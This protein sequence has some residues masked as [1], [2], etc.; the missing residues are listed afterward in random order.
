M[1]SSFLIPLA[2]ALGLSVSI[3]T[4]VPDADA[5][6]RAN[7]PDVISI[8]DIKKGMKGYGL[9]VFEGTKPQ[10]FDVEVIDVLHNFQPR[11][12]LI[13][14]KTMHPRLDVAKIVAGMSGSPI[15]FNGKMAG[16]YAYGWT[17]GVEPVAGVTPIR[18]MLD[19][20]ERP[21]PKLLHGYPLRTLPGKKSARAS[22]KVGGRYA[23]ELSDY[24]V[25]SHSAQ[26][27]DRL[28]PI[29]VPSGQL[30][31]VATPLLM[32]GLS[33]DAVKL[34]EQYLSPLGLQPLQ[35]GG[36][37]GNAKKSAS[38]E[39]Y[40][41]G[42]AV[43]VSLV[44]GDVSA[45]GLGTVTR[46]EGDKLVAFGHPMM[47]IGITSL[48]T[49]RA[50]VL[51]FMASVMRSFKMGEA[52]EA[53]GALVNDRQ[54]SIVV[55]ETIEAPRVDVSLNV[56]GEPGAPYTNWNFKVAH[57]KFLTPALLGVALG[58][59]LTST[60][61]ERRHVTYSIKSQIEFDGFPA[62]EV[63]DYGASPTGTPGASQVMQSNALAAVGKVLNN[64]WQEARVTRVKMDVSL[65]F[66]RD[67]AQLRNVQLLT[68]E[69]DPGK[70]AR[71]RLTFEPF[72]GKVFTRTVAVKVPEY[73][74]GE[75]MRI[76]IKP[77]YTVEPVRA[78]PESLA[79]LISNLEAGTEAPRSLVFSYG[80]GEGGA[81]H[82]GVV[83]ENL[84]PGALDIMTSTS[85][86][87][88]PAQFSTEVRQVEKM[89]LFIV[90]SDAVTVRVR[91][92]RR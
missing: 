36:A 22:S 68:K 73:F 17:F 28:S 83:A 31:P 61:S 35:A 74:A 51:W 64:Q 82:R 15:Y 26:I 55:D 23:G 30:T 58:N 79:A 42:G 56:K 43:G 5:Y 27:A 62:I 10:K 25:A 77:G 3:P 60:A 78:S 12:E 63:E 92:N 91:K 41:D 59:G 32:G 39:G 19:D 13:L 54:S 89:P 66:G 44:S 33:S 70:E 21:L 2:A 72:E 4:L 76:S 46:V 11:Q 16:A 6:G 90:G 88:S 40:V 48:P 24:S 47:N 50:R 8:E 80:S 75:S 29:D 38:S 86:S 84:P 7:R 34:A 45:M 57:D 1:R 71:I 53:L 37:Q 9:T 18:L 85:S 69:V 81:A 20:L 65:T 87:V 52:T 49:T 67:V 14:V